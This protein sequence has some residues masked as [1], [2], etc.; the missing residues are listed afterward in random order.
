MVSDFNPGVQ[1]GQKIFLEKT[2]PLPDNKRLN[3]SSSNSQEIMDVLRSREQLM[4]TVVMSIPT[5]YTGPMPGDFKNLLS[6]NQSFILERMQR[7]AIN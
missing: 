6:Q 7:E 1:A 2:K 4:V 3:F 5:T